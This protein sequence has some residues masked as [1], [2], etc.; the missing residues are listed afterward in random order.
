MIAF[1]RTILAILFTFISTFNVLFAYESDLIRA[2]LKPETEDN[3][4][5]TVTEVVDGDTVMLA[6]GT[7]VRLVG[8][9]APKIALGRKNFI[10]WPLGYESKDALSQIVMGKTVSLYYGGRKMDRYGRALAH[11]FL[12]DG[13]W[14]QGEMLKKGMARVYSFAD[15]RSIVGEMYTEEYKARTRDMGIWALD[16]YKIKPQENSGDHTNSFQ[17]ISGRVLEVATVRNNT[18]LNFGEDYRKDFTIVIPNRV[19]KMFEEKDINLSYL[20]GKN[21]FVRGWL[22]YYNGPSIDLT[23]PEQLVIQ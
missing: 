12:E 23:H 16:F 7:E 20:K 4:S 19:K 8:L 5:S 21:I 18:Y 9:Q 14:V 1:M 11:L 6:N 2:S 17:V 22:K 10:E 15:N 13:T 3:F